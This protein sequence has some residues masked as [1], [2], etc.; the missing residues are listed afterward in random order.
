MVSVRSD[1][2]V[3]EWRLLQ[4]LCCPGSG[5]QESQANQRGH[6]NPESHKSQTRIPEPAIQP[7]HGQEL[8]N[9]ERAN[10]SPHHREKK[11]REVDR[12]DR[13]FCRYAFKHCLRLTQFSKEGNHHRRFA[14]GMI[15]SKITATISSPGYPPP[16]YHQQ[17]PPSL[18]RRENSHFFVLAGNDEFPTACDGSLEQVFFFMSQICSNPR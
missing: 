13:Y 7:C 8:R 12:T 18:L 3:R 4:A 11:R 10:K 2:R 17:I 1:L 6:K 5:R 9:A 14:G 15:R 16:V